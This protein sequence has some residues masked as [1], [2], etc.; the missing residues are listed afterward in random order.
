MH[1]ATNSQ[2]NLNTVKNTVSAPNSHYAFHCIY[3]TSISCVI[4]EGL[5]KALSG[6]T[7]R[8]D[9]GW[10]HHPGAAQ[11]RP[12]NVDIQPD[13]LGVGIRRRCFQCRH[14]PA[15]NVRKSA[16]LRYQLAYSDVRRSLPR[17]QT[18]PERIHRLQ[19]NTRPAQMLKLVSKHTTASAFAL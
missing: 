14:Q 9:R 5:A 13:R 6:P 19:V 18:L 16:A 10:R 17:F 7:R 2:R 15:V 3:L 4:I 1:A 12:D 8:L 11:H